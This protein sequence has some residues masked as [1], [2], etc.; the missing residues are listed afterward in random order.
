MDSRTNAI[1]CRA[2]RLRRYAD[3]VLAVIFKLTRRDFCPVYFLSTDT[4]LNV[5]CLLKCY[6]FRWQADTAQSFQSFE[7]KC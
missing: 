3:P 4:H 7:N 5:H 1:R 6:G 2:G